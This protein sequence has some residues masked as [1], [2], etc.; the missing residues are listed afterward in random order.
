MS[1]L[2]AG[3]VLACSLT[4]TAFAQSPAVNDTRTQY[5]LLLANSYFTINVGAFDY[6]FSPSQLE[7]GF[8]AAAID[9]PRVG[10]RAVLI[11]HEFSPYFSVQAHY[12][13]PVN[14]IRYRNINGTTETHHVLMHFGGVTATTRA[15]LGRHLSVY[16]EAGLGLTSR[17]GFESGTTP[18][19]RDAHY[20]NALLGGG[21]EYH[22]TRNWDLVAGTLF[23]PGNDAQNQPRTLFTSGGFRYTL[24]PLPA[25]IVEASRNAGYVFPEHVVQVSYTTDTFGYGFN[26]LVSKKVPVFWGGNV[27][28]ARG[29][30]AHYEQNVFHTRKTFGL[31]IGGSVGFWRSR[32]N[33][34][35][36]R[37]MSIYP[38]LRWTLVRTAPADMYVA[39]SLAGPSFISRTDADGLQLGTHFTFQDFMG[40]GFFFGPKRQFNAG[41]K[42]NHYSNGNIFN[43]NAGLK[44]PYTFNVGYT[45]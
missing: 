17:D 18:V 22:A 35:W 1:R 27:K 16:G 7:P 25:A 21:V 4:V 24:R 34:E 3:L 44:I 33:R 32:V 41:V 19:V 20:G 15:P 2:A 43:E 12:A 26:T 14:Y 40:L 23:S 31:D 8:T 36:V 37:T 45:F 38:L 5:P 6:P 28:V 9:T 10:V 11:G 39:Y 42:I 29:W 13:R 30:A